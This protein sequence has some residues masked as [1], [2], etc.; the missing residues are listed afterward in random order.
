MGTLLERLAQPPFFC[1]VM[2]IA[3]RTLAA[4]MA[5]LSLTIFFKVG[6]LTFDMAPNHALGGILFEAFYV[7]AV[8]AAV[9]VFFLR[10]RDIEDVRST[11]HY[12]ISVLVLLIKLA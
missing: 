5:L 7:V 12:A 8:Y 10:A 4:L 1:R 3:L 9:H 6:K 11:E 2:S